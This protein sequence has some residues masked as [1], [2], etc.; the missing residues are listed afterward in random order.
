M[1]LKGKIWGTSFDFLFCLAARVKMPTSSGDPAA[2][3][4]PCPFKLLRRVKS[5]KANDNSCQMS[6]NNREGLGGGL[7]VRQTGK[8]Y[9][10]YLFLVTVLWVSALCR[11]AC[12]FQRIRCARFQLAL[13][14]RVKVCRTQC[15]PLVFT[16][17]L[18]DRLD[19]SK[20]VGM[21]WAGSLLLP[22][23][24]ANLEPVWAPGTD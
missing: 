6:P 23:N 4:V 15:G 24:T 7:L 14:L 21:K 18:A 13:T 9:G 11:G 8:T 5:L 19:T 10:L 2:L 17:R 3:P 1:P 22:S 20:I 12:E 16:A